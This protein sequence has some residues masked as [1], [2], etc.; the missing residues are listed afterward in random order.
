M[1]S[2]VSRSFPV[3]SPFTV[4]GRWAISRCSLVASAS[5]HPSLVQR[6]WRPVAIPKVHNRMARCRVRPRRKKILRNS[7]RPLA[8]RL[9]R[10]HDGIG[11][12]SC[13]ASSCH[14]SN[15]FF[16]GAVRRV[17]SRL[18]KKSP[19]AGRAKQNQRRRIPLAEA[20]PSKRAVKLERRTG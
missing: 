1:R 20:D 10:H 19:T 16:L 3:R 6:L 2:L 5:S 12:H 15:R 13:R 9:N 4:A 18:P 8:S 7:C 14:G 17:T 11:I